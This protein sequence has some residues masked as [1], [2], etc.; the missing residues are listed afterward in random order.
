MKTV[1]KLLAIAAM[2]AA[3]GA[4]SAM[5]ASEV[6]FGD[7]APNGGVGIC[8]HTGSDPGL[9]CPQGTSFTDLGV[10]FTATGF[11]DPFSPTGGGAVTLKPETTPPGPPNNPF[12][13]S[14]LGENTAG[15]GVACSDPDCEILAPTALSV[16]ATGGL[17]NDAIIG[18]VQ[19]GESFNFWTGPNQANFLGMFTGGSSPECTGAAIPDTCVITFAN[20]SV[21]W[22]QADS[23]NVL[24][25]A[26]SGDFTPAPEPA[27]LALLGGALFSVGLLHRR[28][29]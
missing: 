16:A 19:A 25:S 21:I 3:G 29:G 17:M 1:S 18:S 6:V 8:S 22:L 10:T 13:E 20:T 23:A 9:V 14:G 11:N 24:I 4:S 15:P 27:S 2:V 12:N 28:R 7:L 5:A 26:V